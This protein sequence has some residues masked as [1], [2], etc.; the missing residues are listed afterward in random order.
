MV[1]RAVCWTRSFLSLKLRCQ[2]GRILVEMGQSMSK[3]GNRAPEFTCHL[4]VQGKRLHELARAG[5]TVERPARPVMITRFDVHRCVII[6]VI[7]LITHH[8]SRGRTRV[9]CS[10]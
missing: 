5:E 7:A 3:N 1:L 10:K 8:R 6:I 2:L 9:H 4:C